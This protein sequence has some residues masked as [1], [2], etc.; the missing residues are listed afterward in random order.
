M[1]VTIKKLPP[2]PPLGIES[3]T[4]V[5]TAAEAV[6]FFS[7]SRKTRSLPAMSALYWKLLTLY[8]GS[9]EFQTLSDDLSRRI[10]GELTLG[11]A[12]V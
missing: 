9:A 4:L 5:L 2:T 3:V 8:S 1:E 12:S 7:V 10:K 11:A 6:E